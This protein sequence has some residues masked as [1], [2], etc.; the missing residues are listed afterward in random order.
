MYAFPCACDLTATLP[1]QQ[2]DTCVS[3]LMTM[4]A[5]V[6]P[7]PVLLLAACTMDW[8]WLSVVYRYDLYP[9]VKMV[10][11]GPGQQCSRHKCE[12]INLAA[13]HPLPGPL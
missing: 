13:R 3:L 7:N 1:L 6:G 9:Y 12:Y 2:A 4:Y 8:Q 10:V 11:E 5:S